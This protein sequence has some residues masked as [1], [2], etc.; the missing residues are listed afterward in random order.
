MADGVYKFMYTSS[1]ISICLGVSALTVSQI[2]ISEFEEALLYSVTHNA[3]L[4]HA[5]LKNNIDFK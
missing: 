1:V 4:L 5:H 2:L 3:T